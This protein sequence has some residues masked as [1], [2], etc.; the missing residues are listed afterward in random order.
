M[1][2]DY[3][4]VPIYNDFHELLSF[5]YQERKHH[6]AI[7]YF[8]KKEE[9]S[10]TYRELLEEI[11]ALYQFF[12]AHGIENCNIGIL[13]ENR[14]EYV[15]MYLSGV[16]S[17][18]VAPIDKEITEEQCK[19]L[20]EKFDIE[21]LFYTNKTE[22]I[23]QE[24]KTIAE[25]V[26]MAD[27]NET[28]CD[29]MCT[30]RRK[31]CKKS[32]NSNNSEKRKKEIRFINIDMLY[33]TIIKEYAYPV[34]S[35]LKDTEDVDRYKCAV[36]VFTSGTTGELK[37]VMLSQYNILSNLRAAVE[38]NI[39]HSPTLSVLPMNHTYGFHPGVLNTLYSGNTL[40]LNLNLKHIVR[41]LKHFNPYFIAVVPMI[42]EGMYKNI[43]REA[44]RTKRYATLQRMIQIS[45]FLLKF[46]ID[47]RHLFFG[48]ILCKNLRVIV[49]GGAALNPY[50]VERFEE[51]GIHL[52]NGYGLTECA[53]LVAVNRAVCNVPGSVGTII[54]EDE[55]QIAEDGEIWV[56]GPNVMLG[57][58]NDPE[59]TSACMVEGYYKTGDLGYKDGNILY[60][61]GRKKNL[62]ILENGKNFSPE[63]IEEKLLT[64]DYIQECL[65]TA[66]KRKETSMVVALLFSETEIDR[67][68]LEK[69]IKNINASL[70]S[71]MQI[72][73][74][75]I[76]QAAF[77]KTSTKKIIR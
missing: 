30:Y 6:P 22:S 73:D 36:L 18:V 17:N 57:Y 41:D 15:T 45:N 71:Y 37:G 10:M 76:M 61:T 69:D 68:R 31:E 11:G 55:V 26:H 28:V 67:D 39:L 66:R 7:R 27:K 34:E 74:Y 19:T 13:S 23:I 4:K 56:K 14:Y 65:V 60:V 54:R 16:F 25:N 33:Q 50:Y 9:V 52:L 32:D 38:N 72:D 42:A 48:N 8:D 44:K 43:I 29:N 63:P 2:Q 77:E 12:K 3:H 75:E 59:A 20:I 1:Q 53:P 46:K 58:Y 35:F 49:S 21:V 40:C 51:L 62:I 5:L 64:L 24:M 70:P 47:V